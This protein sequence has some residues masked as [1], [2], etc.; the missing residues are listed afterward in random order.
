MPFVR[1]HLE[2]DVWTSKGAAI[3]DAIHAAQLALPAL[4][5]PRD[6]VFQVFVPHEPGELRYHPTYLDARRDSL[7]VI[8]LTMQR[9]YD[10]ETPPG[11]RPTTSSSS[12]SRTVRPTGSRARSRVR[13]R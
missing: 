8:E 1:V 3:G 4:A 9:G 2:R 13:R 10:D 6:D 7:V 12:R 11:Y 5:I